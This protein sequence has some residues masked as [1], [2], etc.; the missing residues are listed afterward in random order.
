M[1]LPPQVRFKGSHPCIPEHT[2]VSLTA[3]RQS[4]HLKGTRGG[5]CVG[6]VQERST[7]MALVA[8]PGHLS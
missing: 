1:L 5:M 8:K 6:G 7:G 2:P 4:V 3:N